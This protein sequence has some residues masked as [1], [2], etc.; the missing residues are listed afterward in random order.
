M[1]VQV[2]NAQPDSLARSGASDRQYVG[3]KPELFVE[4]ISGG[5]KLAHLV[6]R[7]DDIPRTLCVWQIGQ[8]VF[9]RLPVLDALVM[10]TRQLQSGAQAATQPVDGRRSQC[11]QQAIPPILQL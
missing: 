10:L 8:T 11:C 6:V 7:Q 1:F 9:P 4:P 3:E 5:H 2:L